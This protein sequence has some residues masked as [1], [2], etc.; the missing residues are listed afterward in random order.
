MVG[1]HDFLDAA[2]H[3]RIAPQRAQLCGQLQ[4]T[5]IRAAVEKKLAHIRHRIRNLYG[6]DFAVA[7][8]DLIV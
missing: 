1:K 5:Q 3:K 4:T 8:K 7:A 6:C 2:P